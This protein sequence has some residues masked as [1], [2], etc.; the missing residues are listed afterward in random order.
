[1]LIDIVRFEWRYHTR[2]PS[3]AGS[4]LLFLIL[5]YFFAAT[6]FGPAGANF[7]SPSSII[8]ASGLLSLASVFVAAIFCIDAVVRDRESKLEEIIFSTAAPKRDFLLGRFVG[9][10]LATSTAVLPCLLGQMVGAQLPLRQGTIGAFAFLAYLEA[11]ATMLLPNVF[12]VCVILFV[13]AALTRSS[14]A[15]YTASM[16]IYVFYLVTAMLTDSP[17][18]AGASREATIGTMTALADPFGLSAYFAATGFWTVAAKN[19]RL[20]PLDGLFGVNRLLWICV[21]VAAWLVLF[22]AFHFRLLEARRRSKTKPVTA[23]PSENAAFAAPSGARLHAPVH[24]GNLAALARSTRL[25]IALLLRNRAFLVLAL[26]WC[27]LVGIEMI[28]DTSIGEYGAALMPAGGTLAGTLARPLHL[29]C[30]VLLIYF[31]GEVVWRERSVRIVDVINAASPAG[32]VF[33]ASKWAALAVMFGAIGL[34]AVLAGVVIQAALSYPLQPWPLLQ[35][36]L[37]NEARLAILSAAAV[38]IH[39]V[40]RS[41]HV[42]LLMVLLLVLVAEVGERVGL[43]PL[44]QLANAPFGEYSDVTGLRGLGATFGAWMGHWSLLAIILSL[45]AA[46]RWRRGLAPRAPMGALAAATAAFLVSGCALYYDTNVLKEYSTPDDVLEWKAAYERKYSSYKRLPRPS[47]T[48]IA[49]VVELYPNEERYRV[50]GRLDLR[51]DSTSPIDR[52]LVAVR[53]D[54]SDVELRVSGATPTATDE[55]FGQTLFE[56]ATPLAPGAATSLRFDL[57]YD[58]RGLRS[59]RMPVTANGTMLQSF[60]IFPSIGYRRGYEIEDED[61]RKEFG[62]AATK[63]QSR[64]DEVPGD[65]ESDDWTTLDLTVSTARGETAVTSGDLVK[66]WHESDRSFFRYVTARP[67]RNHISIASSRYTVES[68]DAAG[69]NVELHFHPSHDANV[70]RILDTTRKALA[71]HAEQFG[72]YPHDALRIAEVPSSFA[73]GGYAQPGALYLGERRVMQVDPTRSKGVDLVARRVAHEVAHQWWGLGLAPANVDGALLI[74]ESLAKYSEIVVTE[75][76][77]GPAHTR[78]LLDFELDRYL[79]GRATATDERPLRST[80]GD[81]WLYYAKGAIVLNAIRHLVGEE[82]MNRAL[83]TFYA[84]HSGPNGASTSRHLVEALKTAAKDDDDRRLIEQ[85]LSDTAVYD[86]RVTDAMAKPLADGR[87]EVSAALHAEHVTEE[88]TSHSRRA[89]NERLAVEIT[90][91]AGKVL[92]STAVHMRGVSAPVRFVVTGRPARITIDP[93]LTR[94]DPT[95]RDNTAA[96]ETTARSSGPPA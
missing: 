74:T 65:E 85:W 51:N 23:E 76:M 84:R 53:D 60:R 79:G 52:F 24:P 46:A 92:L 55:L 32:L 47:V 6:G 73:V 43:H 66:Q 40:A 2:Q 72:R 29:M 61:Q 95:Q 93:A 69:K 9:A 44:L 27:V 59:G 42:G 5:G 36:A 71:Y 56:L 89:T 62:L 35:V 67:V 41:K 90:D 48:H 7:N 22:R 20:I 13:V 25:E 83:R 88:G 38:L 82:S 34:S 49:A 18:M 78:R 31:S 21:A 58:E 96:L 68:A 8:E 15:T 19:S 45:L 11:A 10:F 70:A 4:S 39:T 77:L 14:V 94:I 12:F 37:A 50:A 81:P 16:F 64:S 86:L 28:S 63:R 75:E 91:D 30:V 54:A 3:Y 33:V 80:L 57:A 1:M 17:M 87:Y 26:L